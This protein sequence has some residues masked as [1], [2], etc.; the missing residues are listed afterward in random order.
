MSAQMSGRR[1]A[2]I[3]QLAGQRGSVQG[4]GRKARGVAKEVRGKGGKAHIKGTGTSRM[5]VINW[6]TC[7][8]IP[9]P[10]VSAPRAG[11]N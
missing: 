9:V 8:V 1:G 5:P 2:E 6:V 3:G 4:G 11:S 10:G 7:H